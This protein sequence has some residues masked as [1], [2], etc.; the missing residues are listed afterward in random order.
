[1]AKKNSTKAKPLGGKAAAEAKA[2]K[3]GRKGAA[4]GNVVSVAAHP[5]A[6]AHVRRAKGWCGLVGFVLA[7]YLSLSASVPLVQAGERAL[8]AGAVGYLIGWAAS[9]TVWRQLLL[10]EVRA[11]AEQIAARRAEAFSE[12][13]IQPHD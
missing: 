3:Q 12:G 11:A 7:A 10:A 8:I 4:D 5:R 13:L 6:A 1:M 9:V 2:R